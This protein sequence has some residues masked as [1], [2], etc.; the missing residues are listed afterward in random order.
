M[1]KY[2]GEKPKDTLSYLTWFDRSGA[3]QLL[4]PD[5]LLMEEASSS[6]SVTSHP[7]EEGGNISDHYRLEEKTLTVSLLF[8]NS[9]VRG[10]LSPSAKGAFTDI[11]L[12]YQPEPEKRFPFS[13]GGITRT[14]LGGVESLL[15]LAKTL[16]ETIS[17]FGFDEVPNRIGEAVNVLTRLQEEGILIYVSTSVALYDNMALEHISYQRSNA[18]PSDSITISLSLKHVSFV[19]SK[20]ADTLPVEPR[21]TLGTK[22]GGSNTKKKTEEEVTEKPD[23]RTLAQA[24]ANGAGTSGKGIGSAIKNIFTPLP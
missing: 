24:L 8:S 21:G 7:V 11:I 4:R 23:T 17:A 12:Q 2:I 6:A 9:P 5:L 22:T 10:D 15:G 14:V 18:P 13:P 3:L 20:E 16:P 19:E 1:T